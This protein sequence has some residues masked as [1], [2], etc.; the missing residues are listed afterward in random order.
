MGNCWKEDYN[1]YN[2]LTHKNEI[3]KEPNINDYIID[4]NNYNFSFGK[5]ANS[6]IEQDLPIDFPYNP[7]MINGNQISLETNTNEQSQKQLLINDIN[8]LEEQTIYDANSLKK[9]ELNKLKKIFENSC[10]NGK[11]PSSDDFNQNDWKKF[12]PKDDPFFIIE[13]TD[14]NHNKLI[15]YSQQDKN[16]IKIYQGDLNIFGQRH[17]IG[18]FTTSYYVRIGMWKYDQFCGWGR[19]SRCN[20]DVF[21]GRFENGLLNG[22]GIFLNSKKRKYIG[23]VETMRRSGKGKLTTNNIIYEGE[24]YKDQIHGNGKIKFSKDGTEYIGSFKEGIIDGY[25]IFKWKNG[26]K[27]EGEVKNGKIHGIGKFTYKNG[28]IYQGIFDNGHKVKRSITKS[29]LEREKNDFQSINNN[30]I[31]NSVEDD[32]NDIRYLSTYRNFGFGDEY[33]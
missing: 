15:I 25:G 26:D 21:E 13:D 24:F 23:D 1:I 32:E 12:Y 19:E 11:P 33:N 30:Y 6:K 3:Y 31:N 7:Y 14:I 2:I 29:T 28:K 22:K 5:E 9:K 8:Y 20:G 27:Y 4:E 10:K 18:K 16:N 17:G